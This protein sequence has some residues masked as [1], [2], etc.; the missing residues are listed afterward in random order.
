MLGVGLA[1]AILLD[2]TIV[3]GVLLPAAMTLLGDRCWYMPRWLSRL[4]GRTSAEPGPTN[5][6]PAALVASPDRGGNWATRGIVAAWRGI[7]LVGLTLA[8]L[9][10][11]VAFATAVTL[12]PL[13]IGLPAIPVTVR[14]VRRLETRVRRLSGDWCGAAIGDPYRPEPARREGQ[15]ASFWARFG[16][17][18]ADPA[19]WRDLVWITVDTL[20]GW[21]LT[22]TPAG[23]IAWGLF[24][25]VMPAVWH[26]IVAAHG[27][28]W[29]AFIHVTTAGTAWLSVALGFTFIALGLLTAPWLLRRYGALAQSLLAPA[30][31]P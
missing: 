7:A 28:N 12:A 26:P 4:P 22:L 1:A 25:V 21:L 3:R 10:L 23:L 13:G 31:T 30:R 20:V 9:V 29:Y 8:G 11:W 5:S 14:A 16:F 15:P 27:N 6:R 2:A 17:L 24:G 18:I 19:T